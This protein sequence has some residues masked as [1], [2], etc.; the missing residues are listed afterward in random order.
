MNLSFKFRETLKN[1]RHT[2]DS[3]RTFIIKQG[4]KELKCVRKEKKKNFRKLREFISIENFNVVV[5]I[6]S[7]VKF[8]IYSPT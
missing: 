8:Q 5:S 6:V 2:L 4:N 7:I 1:N 3:Q